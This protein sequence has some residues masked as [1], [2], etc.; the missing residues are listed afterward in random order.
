MFVAVMKTIKLFGTTGFR[1]I[2]ENFSESNGPVKMLVGIY[3]CKHF[4]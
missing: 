4:H 1:L 2:S 3:A